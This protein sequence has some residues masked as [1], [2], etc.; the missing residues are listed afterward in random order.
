[1]AGEES[2]SQVQKRLEEL[3]IRADRSG[4]CTFSSFLT[5]PQA[6][7]AVQIAKRLS[8]D[9]A[10]HGGYEEAER[11]MACFLPYGEVHV[12]WPMQT[13]CL[14]WKHQSAPAHQDVLGA[15]MGLG[16]KR[17]CIGD[18]VLMEDHAYLFAMDAMVEP[19]V[20][21]L[22]SAGRTKL[23][24]EVAKHQE[25]LVQQAGESMRVTVHSLRLDAV[26]AAG[27]SLSRTKIGALIQAGA[28][29]LRHIPNQKVDAKVGVGDVISA[30]GLG[31][32]R[33]EEVF[34]PTKKGRTPVEMTRYGR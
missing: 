6:Q 3:A 29:K 1:M 24:V 28:V 17:S 8:I 12:H 21:G 9:V 32:L 16:M 30:R 23:Q 18:I 19:I 7:V 22:L 5:P 2:L 20:Q 10:L 13:L 4:R 26:V 14:Q 31:R 33:V 15:V 11:E 25:G 34:P 27:F